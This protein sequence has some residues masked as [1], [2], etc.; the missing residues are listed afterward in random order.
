MVIEQTT[1]GFIIPPKQ[2]IV[3]STVTFQYIPFY[4]FGD[5]IDHYH[6]N[7]MDWRLLNSMK[8]TFFNFI[9][10]LPLGVYLVVI[11]GIKNMKSAITILF[12]TTLLI[13]SYQVLFSYF[14]LIRSRIFDVDDIMLNSLGGMLGFLI[15]LLSVKV[16]N[17][18]RV[19][20]SSP[21]LCVNSLS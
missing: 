9:L 21:Y 7:G 3:N 18:M 19:N 6:A 14:G 5:W 10:L 4:F 15:T 12:L 1:G 11:F 2:D 16:I 20:R 8:L 17:K 13:E